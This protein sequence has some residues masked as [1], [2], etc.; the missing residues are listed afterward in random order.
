MSLSTSNDLS[1]AKENFYNCIF[2]EGNHYTFSLGTTSFACD[3]TSA[4]CNN[5]HD[6]PYVDDENMFKIN[7]TDVIE[8][9]KLTRIKCEISKKYIYRILIKNRDCTC[10]QIEFDWCDMMK[11]FSF[12]SPININLIVIVV[13]I[14]TSI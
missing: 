12:E 2:P 7:N 11:I 14:Y 13:L 10:E 1:F 9:L 8:Q 5:I 6:C 4:V 3:S